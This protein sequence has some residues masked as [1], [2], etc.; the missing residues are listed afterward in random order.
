VQQLVATGFG[1][2]LLPEMAAKL[3]RDPRRVYRR[4]SGTAPT[5][6]IGVVWHKHRYQRPLVREFV[7][8]LKE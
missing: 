1:V 3:D 6:T 7:G 8:L 5:R 4:L 2:T